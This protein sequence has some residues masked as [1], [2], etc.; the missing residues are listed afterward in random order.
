MTCPDDEGP[1]WTWNDAAQNADHRVCV[2]SLFGS[3]IHIEK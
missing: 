2:A 1:P 3:V